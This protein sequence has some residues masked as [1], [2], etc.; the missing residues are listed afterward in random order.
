MIMSRESRLCYHAVPKII[1]TNVN[2]INDDSQDADEDRS[3]ESHFSENTKEGKE[4]LLS[5]DI[6][7]NLD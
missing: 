1:K 7:C 6:V 5:K 3:N 4:S 2:W